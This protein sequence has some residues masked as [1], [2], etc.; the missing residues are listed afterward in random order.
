[1]NRKKQRGQKR[2]LNRMLRHIDEFVPFRDMDI[3]F[4]HFHVPCTPFI[5][6]TKTAGS[7]KTAFCRKWL[8]KTEDFIA[9]KPLNIPFCK[10]VAVISEPNF[11]S[12]QIIIFYSEEYYNTFWKRD[13]PYQKWEFIDDKTKSF[14]TPRNIKTDLVEKGYYEVYIDDEDVYKPHTLWF[15]GEL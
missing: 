2:R 6:A 14:V 9:Q 13:G 3:E 10:V 1:M 5:E 15:Y 4:E 8:E 12:S 11:W 7:V